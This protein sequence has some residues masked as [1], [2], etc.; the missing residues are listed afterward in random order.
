[1]PT[2]RQMLVRKGMSMCHIL[3]SLFSIF[4]TMQSGFMELVRLGFL[5]DPDREL[6]LL[7][8]LQT[9]LLDLYLTLL[10]GTDR[11]ESGRRSMEEVR[12]HIQS[13]FSE[14][15]GLEDLPGRAASVSGLLHSSTTAK[16]TT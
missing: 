16:V 15:L 7:A 13:H 10:R 4:E 3:A 14:P 6:M 9:F 1:M 12:D 8:R 11:E 2:P 5:Q